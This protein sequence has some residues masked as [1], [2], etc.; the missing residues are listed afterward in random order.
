MYVLSTPNSTFELPI[1]QC[2][3]QPCAGRPESEAHGPRFKATLRGRYAGVAIHER[4]LERFAVWFEMDLE[5]NVQSAVGDRS[6]PSS[7][8]RLRPSASHGHTNHHE[9]IQDH[10]VY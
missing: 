8:R 4:A 3:L 7:V 9:H 5:W 6:V 2:S 1:R 10:Y